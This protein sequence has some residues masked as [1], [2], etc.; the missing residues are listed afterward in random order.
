MKKLFI[1]LAVLVAAVA[2]SKDEVQ[3]TSSYSAPITFDNSFVNNSTRAID[4]SYTSST[5]QAFDVCG[6]ITASPQNGGQTANIF[7]QEKVEKGALTGVGSEWRYSAANAQYWIPGN[8]Y[9]FV[10]I[11][12]GNKTE[13]SATITTVATDG[14]GMPTTITL[15]DSSKQ[16]DILYAESKNISYNANDGAKTVSFTFSHL[17][18]KAKFTVKNTITA[19]NSGYSYKVKDVKI[20]Y[21]AKIATYTVSTGKW[22]TASEQA[23]DLDFGHIVAADAS[24]EVN[25]PINIAIGGSGVSNYERLLIPTADGQPRTINVS[26]TRELYKSGVLVETKEVTLAANNLTLL[27]GN[28]YNFVISLGNPGEPIQFTVG[29]VG[30]W[31]TD[32]DDD[33]TD[34]DETPIP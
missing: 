25:E 27:K 20:L 34:E 5:L 31:D 26:F 22:G 11:A 24:T 2:C 4:G 21:P 29:N 9:N 28:A 7:E 3:S 18:A 32:H 17:M 12:D 1:S 8:T 13:G 16:L 19:T 23:S 6:T 14:N 33:G 15:N 30:A 10:A